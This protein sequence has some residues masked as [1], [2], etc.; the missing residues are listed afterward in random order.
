[1]GL[2][3]RVLLSRAGVIPSNYSGF[4]DEAEDVVREDRSLLQEQHLVR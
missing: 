4:L 1:M 3:L 2:I